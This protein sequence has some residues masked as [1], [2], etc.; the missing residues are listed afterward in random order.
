MRTRRLAIAIGLW[1]VLGTWAV[2]HAQN[3]GSLPNN[4][5]HVDASI[6]PVN[7][8]LKA[9]CGYLY[10][11]RHIAARDVR[12]EV[13]GLDATRSVLSSRARS[14]FGDIGPSGRAYFCVPVA[15]E[16]KAFGFAV[17]SA[18]WRFSDGQ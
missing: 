5:F 2:V 13:M 10:N 16:A 18:D 11:D 17:L 3:F 6:G 8:S 14:I 9:F 15:A 4:Y 12:I 7:G 1:G